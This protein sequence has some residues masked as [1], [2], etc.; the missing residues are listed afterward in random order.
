[1]KNSNSTRREFLKW[2]AGLTAMWSLP[3]CSA[4]SQSATETHSAATP[5]R[6]ML[7]I[8]QEVARQADPRYNLYLN[9]E[10]ASLIQHMLQNHPTQKEIAMLA[11]RLPV[12]LLDAGETDKAIRAYSAMEHLLNATNP[13]ILQNPYNHYELRLHQ[14]LC[15][16]RLGEQQNCCAMHN[17]ESCLA[18]LR[19]G[20]IYQKK[21][22]GQQAFHLLL[23]L[24]HEYPDDLTTRWLLNITAM[25]LGEWPNSLPAAMLIPPSCFVSSSFPRFF[26]RS[27]EMGL[28]LSGLAGSVVLDD[29]DGD[30]NLDIMV[31]E[32]GLTDQLRYFRNNG[33]G[34]FT[35]RTHEAGLEGEWGGLNLLSADYNNDGNLDVLVLRGAWLG[36]E[37]H[38]PLSLLRNNGKGVFTDVTLE[39]GLLRFHPTQTAVWFDYNG[40]GLLDLFVGNESTEGD[41]NPCEL[42]RNNGDGTFSNVTD[43]CNMGITGWVKSVVCADYN[44]D[45]RPDLYLSLRDRIGILL[46]NDG[47]LQPGGDAK[48]AWKFTDVS[49]EAG[50]H[51]PSSGFASFF[52]DYD[53]NGWSDLFVAGYNVDS[54]G[55]VAADMLGL[56]VSAPRCHLYRNNGD[57]TFTDV[58]RETGLYHVMPAMAAN[59]GDLDNDGWLDFYLGTGIPDL[60]GLMPNRMWRNHEG[61]FF[62]DVTWSGDFG[63]LQKGHGIAFGDINNNGFQDV[64][65]KMGGAYEGDTA[66]SRLF[67]NPGNENAW[68]VLELQGVKANRSA[69]GARIT[70]TVSDAYAVRQ[71]HRTVGT[72]G[73]FGC[74]PLRQHIGLGKTESAVSVQVVWPGS[75]LHQRWDGL[76]PR[77]F[78]RLIEGVE[79]AVRQELS[80]FVLPGGTG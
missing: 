30:G 14:A 59:F 78:Y 74:N 13:K 15:Y 29:L 57:G 76:A 56:P 22:A 10:R 68:I 52:F 17:A 5:V 62:Q 80:Q 21:Q 42:F 31:S 33:N 28:L 58:S 60:L 18:P 63:N 69:L 11:P 20:G 39:A 36:K 44:N 3:G 67:V 40:D 4:P 70:A 12:E 64:F 38:H 16:M 72:G 73:S 2:L 41:V 35:E 32:W 9:R 7:D 43:L 79:K 75:G 6:N 26:D 46:R 50:I 8:L 55:T 61:K 66:W 54:A 37:G 77:T 53:N 34:T 24:L 25:T 48:S 65:E 71:I 45:G 23:H 1:M 47:P 51:N 49:V 19:G 27:A